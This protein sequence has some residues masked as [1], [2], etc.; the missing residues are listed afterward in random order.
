MDADMFLLSDKTKVLKFSLR[1]WH[2]N[3]SVLFLFLINPVAMETFF[4]IIYL[5][6]VQT[7]EETNGAS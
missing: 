1:V 3:I 6:P 4:V 5:L 7:A 2:S